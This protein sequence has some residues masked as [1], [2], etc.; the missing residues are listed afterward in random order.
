M[1]KKIVPLMLA[2]VSGEASRLGVSIA[3]RGVEEVGDHIEFFAPQLDVVV[4][5]RIEAVNEVSEPK[6]MKEYRPDPNLIERVGDDLSDQV[7]Q[8]NRRD[9]V[10]CTGNE[11]KVTVTLTTDAYGYETS[12]I[13]KDSNNNAVLAMP[14]I[15]SSFGKSQTYIDSICLE[16]GQYTLRMKDSGGD[17]F[18]SSFGCG[19]VSVSVDGSTVL[20]I[21]NDKSEWKVVDKKFS[22]IIFSGRGS[23]DTGSS[24]FTGDSGFVS[25]SCYDTSVYTKIDKYGKET[26]WKITKKGSSSAIAKMNAELDAYESKTV[27]AGCLQ[28]GDYTL[29]FTDID[30]ICCK[31]GKGEFRLIVDGEELFSGGSF[32]GSVSH[33]FKIGYD[34]GEGMQSRDWEFLQAHNTRRDD[35]HTRCNDKYCGKKARP[36]KWSAGL[37]ADAKVYAE[38]LLDSCDN[39]G[40]KHDPGVEQ[41]ENLAKNKGSGQWGELY[42]ADK[43]VKRFVDNEEFWGWHRNAHLTQAMWYATRY[44]GCGESVMTMSN[45][46]TC[47][48]QVCRYAKAG[49]C[50]M[51]LYDSEVGDNWMKPMMM[52]DSPCGPVCPPEGCYI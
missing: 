28:P 33:D 14:E 50:E 8:F 12:Y 5:R 30:G 6:N 46:E 22:V 7:G 27:D 3:E 40:I 16:P 10:T 47:R 21:S 39:Q 48:M 43:I 41:G 34:W 17:G 44:L 45:G 2:A 9:A 18:C 1:M 15:G 19:S 31:N 26:T 11:A 42:D 32:I 37:A 20:D 52:D 29:T 13:I 36:L 25:K 49:N 51:G 24:S 38:K 35:W 4:Q 23:V